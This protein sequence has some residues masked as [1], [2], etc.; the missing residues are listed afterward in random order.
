ML[1]VIVPA[2]NEANHIYKNL[3]SIRDE[4]ETFCNDFEIIFVDDGSSDSTASEARKAAEQIN[5]IEVVTYIKNGGKGHA[6]KEGFKKS[7]KEL[8]TFLDGDLDIPP[9]QIKQLLN[10]INETGAD[11]VVQSKRHRDS[12]VNGFPL[13]RQYLSK[14]YNLMVK[15]LFH[16][17]VSDTQV[18]IKL[19][20]RKV[21]ET[22]M[23]KLLVK[24]YAADVEQILLAHKYGYKIVECPVQINFNQAGDCIGM[25]D[26]YNIGW[27]TVAVYYRANVL[28][29]YDN[30][31]TNQT[32]EKK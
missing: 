8:I 18:G 3:L 29:Y 20:R 21:L 30:V 32:N 17:P 6:I 5:N 22:I 1:S 11:V 15:Q 9:K 19:F 7:S 14:S 4:L 28:K 25:K 2:Y 16:L 26:I 13:R 10:K 12:I 24:R 31:G 23:P 27:D